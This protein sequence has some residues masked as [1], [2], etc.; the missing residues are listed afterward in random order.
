MH[1][2]TIM[3]N[4]PNEPLVGAH[5]KPRMMCLTPTLKKRGSP[6][7]RIKMNMRN[8]K[9]REEKAKTVR[10]TLTTRSLRLL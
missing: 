8:R 7:I 10:V 1:E 6:S 2:D 3:G 5:L 4:M 9:K